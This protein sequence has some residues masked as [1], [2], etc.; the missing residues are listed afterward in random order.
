STQ[1]AGAYERG[2]RLLPG[3]YAP[4]DQDNR[5]GCRSRRFVPLALTSLRAFSPPEP[6]P[7]H[8]A[9][10]LQYRAKGNPPTSQPVMAIANCC[11]GLE[12]DFRAVWRRLFAEIELSEWENYVIK[13]TATVK[14]KKIN[15]K[16][17]RL[18]RVDGIPVTVSLT[19]PSPEDL[20]TSRKETSSADSDRNADAEGNPIVRSDRNPNGVR[21]MEW[22]N[23][24]AHVLEALRVNRKRKVKCEFTA[25]P[26]KD[27][28]PQDAKAVAVT[29][30]VQDFFEPGTAVISQ[31]LAKPGELTEGLCSPWQNDLRECS[32]FYWASS[33][34]DFVNTKIGND[35]LTHGDYWFARER[36]G[37]YVPDDY[38]DNRLM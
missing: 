29:L 13:G 1:D 26:A 18:L 25:T 22:S 20:V 38:A 19:G 9:A 21:T 33:R 35:G 10:P 30:T 4:P 17:H 36:T 3:A 15:L 24:L 27:P 23:C 16:G 6:L 7:C 28:Q 34:P 37:K 5:K 2:G 32:C 8:L 12:V 31:E 14:G 11:P